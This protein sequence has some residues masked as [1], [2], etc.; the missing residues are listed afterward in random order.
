MWVFIK[1]YGNESIK[2][3]KP[4]SLLWITFRCPLWF[5]NIE[6]CFRAS[7]SG[8]DVH[9]RHLSLIKQ[10]QTI[11]LFHKVVSYFCS[12]FVWPSW[13]FLSPKNTNSYLSVPLVYSRVSGRDWICSRNGKKGNEQ[14]PQLGLEIGSIV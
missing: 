10:E 9:L 5:I 6:M 14:T 1:I 11:I 4:I 3:T 7:I 8:V 2:Q 12:L 13:I